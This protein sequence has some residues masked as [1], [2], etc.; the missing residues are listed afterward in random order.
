MG[1]NFESMVKEMA[2]WHTTP[3]A[4]ERMPAGEPPETVE[5]DEAELDSEDEMSPWPSSGRPDST[6][7]KKG[8]PGAT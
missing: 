2:R 3:E 8:R 7:Q 1:S 4:S 6:A 5:E